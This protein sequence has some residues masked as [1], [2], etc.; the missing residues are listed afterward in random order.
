[1][2]LVCI[3]CFVLCYLSKSKR[4]MALVFSEDFQYTF[5]IKVFL[6][7]TLPIDQVPVLD[8]IFLQRMMMS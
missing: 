4:D 5:S 2:F 1:M 8:L 7:N 3:C 6:T